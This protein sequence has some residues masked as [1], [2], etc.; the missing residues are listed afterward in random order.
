MT[1]HTWEVV[2]PL[3]WEALLK[4]KLGETL[5]FYTLALLSLCFLCADDT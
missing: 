3:R 4:V 2:E 5:K 1:T